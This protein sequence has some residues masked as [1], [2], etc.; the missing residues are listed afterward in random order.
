MNSLA[1]IVG[2]SEGISVVMM[3]TSETF[4]VSSGMLKMNLIEIEMSG[5]FV[6]KCY[7]R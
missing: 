6:L 5:S 7:K 3:A 1:S 4:Q 2:G